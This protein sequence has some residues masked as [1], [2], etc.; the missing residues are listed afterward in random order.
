MTYLPITGSFLDEITV[1]I[2]SQNWGPQEW[3]TEFATFAASGIDTVVLIRAGCGERLACPSAAIAERVPTL[4]V[5]AD[6]VRL[7]LDLAAEHGITFYLGLYDSNMFWYRYDWQTE[8]DVNLAFIDEV[9]DRYAGS[10]ALRWLSTCRTRPPIPSYGSWTSTRRWPA[11]SSPPRRACP[12]WSR[13]SSSAAATSGMAP[14]CD[15]GPANLTNT[16]G[17]GMRSS[18]ATRAWLTTAPSRTEPPTRCASPSTTP[19]APRLPS[20]A[21]DPLLGQC[22]DVRPGYR[23]GSRPRTGA[24]IG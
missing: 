4:P 11:G 8:L 17:S 9:C 6:L 1:D 5:Y 3:A 24:S 23:S 22:R 16:P 20:A 18:A 7:F 10:P 13:R 14:T 21:R 15:H 2:P 12:S 19:P